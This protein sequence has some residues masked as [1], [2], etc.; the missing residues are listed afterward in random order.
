MNR[1]V[2]I[3]ALTALTSLT[4]LTSLGSGC[5]KPPA[6]VAGTKIPESDENRQLIKIVERY[7]QAVERKDAGALLLMASKSYFEDGGTQS[8][9]D[10]YGYEGL[11]DVLAG[12]FQ[13]ANS[14]RYSVRY[15]RIRRRGPRAFVEIFVDA[16]FSLVDSTGGERREEVRDQNLLVLIQENEKWKFVSGM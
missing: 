15:V 13:A 10:D 4:L 3:F 2:L 11:R 16:S 5:A 7:R 1:Q 8:G 12:R 9:K 6:Y 14:I